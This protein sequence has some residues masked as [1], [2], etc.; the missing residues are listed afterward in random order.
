VYLL[1]QS[2]YLYDALGL[3]APTVYACSDYLLDPRLSTA[4]IDGKAELA[5]ILATRPEFI[6]LSNLEDFRYAPRPC[7]LVEDRLA[8][9]YAVAYRSSRC[10]SYRRSIDAAKP[11]TRCDSFT[12]ATPGA[13]ILADARKLLVW[14]LIRSVEVLI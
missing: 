13:A 3:T 10:T 7:E 14:L 11:T 6:V 9:S 1:E 2:P 5:R 8:S 4:G 12:P